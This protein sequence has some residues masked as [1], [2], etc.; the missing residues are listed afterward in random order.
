MKKTE[1][2]LFPIIVVPIQWGRRWRPNVRTF[3]TFL[4][5]VLWGGGGGK[6]QALDEGWEMYE[7]AAAKAGINILEMIDASSL[8]YYVNAACTALRVDAASRKISMLYRLAGWDESIFDGAGSAADSSAAAAGILDFG[9]TFVSASLALS[10]AQ[11]LLCESP[12]D[13]QR[14]IARAKA[15][16]RMIEKAS[17]SASAS[18]SS[19]S[20][21][22]ASYSENPSMQSRSGG[23]RGSNAV[24]G[25]E[26]RAESNRRFRQHKL[27]E[28][29]RQ[30]EQLERRSADI[31]PESWSAE[32]LE[33]R[34]L[35]GGLMVFSTGGTTDHEKVKVNA[36]NNAKDAGRGQEDAQDDVES[37][38][39]EHLRSFGLSQ[40]PRKGSIE[41]G[42]PKDLLGQ[43][44][45]IDFS[46]VF[47]EPGDSPLHIELGSGSG[48]WIVNQAKSN[49]GVNYVS[50]EMRVDRVGQTFAS[51]CLNVQCDGSKKPLTNLAVAGDEA[52]SFLTKR[53]RSG[54]VQAIFVNHP[55][56]PS[57]DGG[58]AAESEH[59]LN[60]NLM[61]AARSALLPGGR[62]VIVSDNLHYTKELAHSLSQ[63]ISRNPALYSNDKSALAGASLRLFKS[64]RSSGAA[65]AVDV[66]EGTPSRSLGYA[67]GGSSYFDKLWKTGAG[68]H[69]SKN[70][71]YIISLRRPAQELGQG[72]TSSAGTGGSGSKK[73]KKSA[74]KQARRNERRLAKKMK[75]E[76][77]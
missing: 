31:R 70:N 5:A 32:K 58:A 47:K 61:L 12:S 16:A 75:S 21:L 20:S 39:R 4:R 64:V 30:L 36:V 44:G 17:Y 7:N 25:N 66:L 76:N 77:K 33:E 34:M 43:D 71:R 6:G 48:D 1:I 49:P 63:T 13:I 15:C 8:E 52:M 24:R 72:I 27:T 23:K 62:M 59:M 55:E 9:E 51:A 3:N 41:I 42:H 35:G 28:L 57:Q 46:K 2:F 73:R 14:T 19:S 10:R 45:T 22:S 38:M 65:G 67:K 54:S 56:P 29:K 26:Q 50:V 37:T 69:A 60:E 11:S 18:L 40:L 74:A 68:S 53:I